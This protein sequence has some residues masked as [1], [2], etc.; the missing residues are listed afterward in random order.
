LTHCQ[1][2]QPPSCYRQLPGLFPVSL[3]NRL[4]VS[5]RH[6]VSMLPT[7]AGLRRQNQPEKI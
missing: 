4:D 5:S 7:F 1:K 2:G 3:I 6:V